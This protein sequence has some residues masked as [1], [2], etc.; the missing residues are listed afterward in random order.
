MGRT[1]VSHAPPPISYLKACFVVGDNSG[2]LLW[3]SRPPEHFPERPEDHGN[4]NAR[5]AGKPAG[6]PI[7][8]ETFV[9]VQFN[10]RTRR[11]SALRTAWILATGSYPVG[12]VE[13]RDGDR[14][15]LRPA[16]LIERSRGWRRRGGPS[17]KQRMAADAAL[18]S[19]MRD[20]PDASIAQIS[21]LVGSAK[22]CV[23]RR[24]AKLAEAGLTCGPMCVPSRHWG[25]TGAGAALAASAKPLVDEL[26]REL[27][28]A[29]RQ[30]DH[31][32]IASVARRVEGGCEMTVRRRLRA[33]AERGLVSNGDGYS[34]TE[35]G[36]DLAGPRA[37]W[38]TRLTAT[39]ERHR[40]DLMTFGRQTIAL[41][42]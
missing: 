9:R 15:N 40:G 37:P 26:D 2:R 6:F 8:G 32:S 29:L 13:A 7:N 1:A 11:I 36:R 27:L 25:L 16:N 23:C 39:Q 18:L 3:R 10:G 38:V 42:G 5:F 31:A 14:A 34:L 41:Y 17:L 20:N 21:T 28:Q 30:R 12:P 4:W 19:A 33:L 35:A 24:L 22:P